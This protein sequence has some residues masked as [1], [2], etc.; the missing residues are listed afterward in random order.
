MTPS[1]PHPRLKD[2][3]RMWFTLK[4]IPRRERSCES[5]H[6]V[7]KNFANLFASIVWNLWHV[8]AL[9]DSNLDTA[10]RITTFNPNPRAGIR[11]RSQSPP[12]TV[13]AAVGGSCAVVP[14]R[15]KW[16]L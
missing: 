8:N 9:Q 2:S 4:D 13:F 10:D 16:H 11:A 15:N 6:L 7:W 14:N 3:L 5:G 1:K 12:C